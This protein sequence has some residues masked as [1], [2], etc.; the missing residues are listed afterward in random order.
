MHTETKTIQE[1]SLK[2]VDLVGN[3]TNEIE[4]Y[5][6]IVVHEHIHGVKPLEYDIREIDEELYL[7]VLQTAKEIVSTS[8]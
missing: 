5:C 3:K 2:A 4:R 8:K 1:L 6:W 7:S